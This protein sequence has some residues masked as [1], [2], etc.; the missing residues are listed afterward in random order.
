[1]AGTCVVL[2]ICFVV[3]WIDWHCPNQVFRPVCWFFSFR[4]IGGYPGPD[5][6]SC[7]VYNHAI[8]PDSSE[9]QWT[10]L[11]SLPSG[12]AGGSLVYITARNA[13]FFTGGAKRTTGSGYK[14]YQ[15]SWL[16][17]LNAAGGSTATWTAKPNLPYF[18]NHMSYV[19][20]KD[21]RG[22]ERYF[23]M[24]G[25]LTANEANGNQKDLY[26][27]DAVNEVWIQRQNMPMGRGHANMATMAVSC[28]FIIAGGAI[29]SGSSGSKAQTNDVSYYDIPSNTWTHIGTL[30]QKVRTMCAIDLV[31][32]YMYCETGVI[33]S[34][35]SSRRQIKV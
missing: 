9:P 30:S 21:N 27:Y 13:L 8:S 1:V 14:D 15:E 22:V 12:R 29:N 3:G 11:P 18:G 26:E 2:G 16:L 7:V 17:P 25:Q 28:G 10:T 33:T 31:N 23:F 6:A 32:N 34:R 20:A 5:T 35:Y 24:G 19:S 4:L